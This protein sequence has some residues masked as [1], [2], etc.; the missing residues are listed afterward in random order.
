VGARGSS[1]VILSQIIRGI[2]ESLAAEE[3]IDGDAV[4][5]VL[6]AGSD[7]AYRAVRKPVEGTMLTAIRTLA[8]AAEAEQSRPVP[9][10][11]ELL[12]AR[13]EEAVARTQ[14]QLDEPGGSG[15]AHAGLTQHVQLLLGPPNRLSPT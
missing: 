6:R 9:E 7:A 14:E 5:R 4:A 12:V 10:L 15:V 13:G 11:L 1:G 8:D 3:S 2:G